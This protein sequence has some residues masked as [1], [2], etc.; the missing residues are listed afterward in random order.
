[1]IGVPELL[2]VLVVLLLVVG[3]S[4]LPKL[5]RAL[6]DSKREIEKGLTGRNSDA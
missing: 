3:A 5:A 2:L 6:G 4:R 1:M